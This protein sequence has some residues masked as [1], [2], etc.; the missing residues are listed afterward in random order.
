MSASDTIR[1]KWAYYVALMR[2]ATKSE[3]GHHVGRLVFDEPRQQETAL[4]ALSALITELGAAAQQGTQILYAT[5]GD[6]AEL[7]G[8]L[9]GVPHRA[10]RSQGVV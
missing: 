9:A 6:Q 7:N 2:T 1:T 5:S 10:A 8:A 3:T 4:S